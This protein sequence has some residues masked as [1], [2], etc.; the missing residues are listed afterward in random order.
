MH[1]LPFLPIPPFLYWVISLLG[2]LFY[3]LIYCSNLAFQIFTH[4]N[5]GIVVFKHDNAEI[6]YKPVFSPKFV[7]LMYPHETSPLFF[8]F[9]TRVGNLIYHEITFSIMFLLCRYLNLKHL[10]V[11]TC[12]EIS[13]CQNSPPFHSP[14]IYA[15]LVSNTEE[16]GCSELIQGYSL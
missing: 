11:W 6:M 5:Q 9:I 16:K 8:F 15:F 13:I 2:Y 1:M 14:G 12:I 7:K 3:L 4:S 10:V